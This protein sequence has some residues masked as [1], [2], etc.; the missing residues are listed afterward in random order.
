[1][2]IAVNSMIGMVLLFVA[3]SFILVY[4]NTY[5]PRYPLNIRPS[6]YH[7]EYEDVTFVTKDGLTLAGWLIK[8]DRIGKRTPAIIICH[9][10]GANKSDFTDLAVFLAR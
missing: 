4:S 5:P 3:L 8:P 10:H 6:D 9:G 1:M 7:R 2:R